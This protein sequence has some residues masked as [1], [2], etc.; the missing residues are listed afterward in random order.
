MVYCPGIGELCRIEQ[1]DAATW[2]DAVS[3]FT[4]TRDPMIAMEMY[5]QWTA[6]GL[7]P[8]KPMDVE[9][10]VDT[11]DRVLQCGATVSIP[12]IAVTPRRAI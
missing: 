4:A 6:R 10:F 11:V 1:L 9:H 8:D 3:Q 2:H 5:P 12:T 7:L